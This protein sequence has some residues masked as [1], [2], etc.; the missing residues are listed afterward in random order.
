M[1]Q[2]IASTAAGLAGGLLLL[3]I[4]PAHAASL[5][6]RVGRIERQVTQVAPLTLDVERLKRENQRLRG[7]IEEQ[8]HA[9]HALQRRLQ[10][11][12][13]DLDQR[14]AENPPASPV[15]EPESEP[16]P[17]PQATGSTA[18]ITAP[19][20]PPAAPAD[21]D[22]ARAAYDA[23]YALLGAKQR[24]YADAIKAFDQFL[25]DYPGSDLADNALYW[26]AEASY[27]L[28][29][30]DTA[31]VVFDQL[32]QQY[33]GSPKVPGA[34]LKTGYILHAQGKI[35]EATAILNRLIREYP[36]SSA[37]D[38]GQRRL[39]RIAREKR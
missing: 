24:K 14:L 28:G 3:S 4:N 19:T 39:D 16:L 13:L 21:P 15:L 7:Q 12:Y 5:E 11:M 27:V 34:L 33:P 32:L 1:G 25:L 8:Q 2:R 31:L 22:K 9:I 6:D 37:A 35:Q 38:M 17:E 26:K 10:D 18:G 23:A 30:N 36:T 29:D 20:V